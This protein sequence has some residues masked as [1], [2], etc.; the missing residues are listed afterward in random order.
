MNSI[1]EIILELQQDVDQ[2]NLILLSRKHPLYSRI[3]KLRLKGG[4]LILKQLKEHHEYL[5]CFLIERKQFLFVHELINQMEVGNLQ[6]Q[7]ILIQ[8]I[9]RLFLP[10]K[11]VQRLTH[12]LKK[13]LCLK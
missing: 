5:F 4:S 10:K 9:F 11:L 8:Q 6:W 13:L 2:F 3:F 12:R 7:Q 1:I